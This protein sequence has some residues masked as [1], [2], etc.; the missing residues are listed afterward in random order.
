MSALPF[1][2]SES[3]ML[4]LFEKNQEALDHFQS[5]QMHPDDS[6][7]RYVPNIACTHA[8]MEFTFSIVFQV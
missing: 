1:S 2:G 8:R 4:R 5:R 7:M 3:N 6:D